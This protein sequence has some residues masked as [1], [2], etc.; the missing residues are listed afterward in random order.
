VALLEGSGSGGEPG[1]P[2]G[3][4]PAR[5][6][7][8]RFVMAGWPGAVALG[9]SAVAVAGV[10]WSGAADQV[11]VDASGVVLV[12]GVVAAVG[13]VVGVAGR[14]RRWWSRWGLGIGVASTAVV[15]AAHWW[16]SDSGVVADHYPPS[17]L[18]WVWLG[19][20]AVGVAATGWWAGA[21]AVRLA[22]TLAAPVALL[23]AFLLINAHYGYWPTVG[24]LMGQPVPGQVS[25][26]KV[27]QEI[28]LRTDGS[29]TGQTDATRLL[30]RTG[31]YGPIDIP[32]VPVAFAASPAWVWLPPAFF[33]APADRLS[34]LLMLT[35]LPGSAQDWVTAGQ[36]VPL[37]DAW[38]RAHGGVAPV[39]IF[40]DENGRGDRDTECVNGPQGAADSYLTRDIPRWVDDTLRIGPEPARWGVVGFSEG[41]TCAIDLAI[42]DPQ[43]FGSFV[44]ISGDLAPNHGGPAAT[45]QYL[46]GGDGLAAQSF[47]PSLILARHHYRHLDGW[48]ATGSGDRSALT[49]ARTLGVLAA[50]AGIAAHAYEGPG[51][52]TWAFARQSFAQIYPGL[53][54]SL[55]GQPPGPSPCLIGEADSDAARLTAHCLSPADRHVM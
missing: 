2:A 17:F 18:V 9:V 21:T 12:V 28:R 44:D 39:M 43:L 11:A 51:G 38:A 20:W 15:A 7:R 16:I 47:Q 24:T 27:Y 14:S 19:V 10:V 25:T 26:P 23:A 46:Y 1:W 53:V 54:A 48:F 29:P 42:Q 3:L 49:V 52:H 40:V 22:R 55:S 32:A 33:H 8:I 37:V 5:A 50:R 13:L 31:M 41:G 6:Q 4:G 34:V 30:A 35:G 36:V 45:L